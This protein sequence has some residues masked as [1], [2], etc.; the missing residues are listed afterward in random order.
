M[1]QRCAAQHTRLVRRPVFGSRPLRAHG[2]VGEHPRDQARQRCGGGDQHHLAVGA[3]VDERCGQRAELQHAA[4]ALDVPALNGVR[5]HG[6]E[7]GPEHGALY[8]HIHE[9]RGD[10]PQAPPVGDQRGDRAL[11]GSVVPRLR[12][13]D[14][15]RAAVGIAAQRHHPAHRRQR[16]IGGQMVRVGA[17]LPEW[18]DRDVDEPRVDR[19]QG[20]EADPARG[21]RTGGGV[22]ENEIGA[23][24]QAQELRTPGGAVEIENDAALAAIEGMEAEAVQVG[25]QA[26]VQWRLVSRPAAARRFDFDHVGAEPGENERPKLS[27]RVGQIHDAIRAQHDQG[28]PRRMILSVLDDASIP[29]RRRRRESGD[30]RRGTVTVRHCVEPTPGGAISR[31]SS[32]TG[33]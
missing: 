26:G 33:R 12:H 24:H 16:Q 8:R 15:D 3:G 25:R 20:V 10:R 23:R 4:V 21:H 9:L 13:A 11:G 2:A 17:V 30:T 14:A 27:A 7:A 6:V 1:R 32:W 29:A 18:R 22:L 5:D 19:T 28:A 31:G